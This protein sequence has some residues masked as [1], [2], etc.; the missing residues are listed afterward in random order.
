MNRLVLICL[1]VVMAFCVA[2]QLA[3]AQ[4]GPYQNGAGM[5]YGANRRGY[6][7]RGIGPGAGYGR[8]GMGPGTG[9]GRGGMGPGAGNGM[10]GLGPGDGYG[11]CPR[12]LL[13][14]EERIQC[15]EDS[16]TYLPPDSIRYARHVRILEAL[17]NNN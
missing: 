12:S 16:L 14:T 11:L 17:K 15:L 6:G 1:C 8:G 7:R 13:T 3:S 10:A 4:Q 2:A 9:Y 5:G